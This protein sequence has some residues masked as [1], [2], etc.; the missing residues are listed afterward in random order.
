V[1]NSQL[2]QNISGV[3]VVQSF[4]REDMNLSQFDGVNQ[5]HLDT[6][7]WAIRL[8]AYLMPAVDLVTA[9]ALGLVVVVGGA[10]ALDGELSPAVLVAFAL[11]VQRFFE[12][13]RALTMQ[14]TQFQRAMTA[15]TRI[16]ELLDVEPEVVDSPDAI[17]L[18]A[19]KGEIHYDNISFEYIKGAPVLQDI[20]LHIMPGQTVALV[21][22][23]G[24]GKTT[25]VSLL[26]RFY[27]VTKGRITVDGHDL[28]DVTRHSLASQMS[29][30][31]QEP[32]LY[33]VTVAENIRFR[34]TDA[35]MERVI[36]AA[37]AVGAHDFIMGLEDGYDTVLQERGGNLSIGQ[38]Q[39]ISFARAILADPQILV[40]DEATANID[41]ITEVLIQS[42]LRE[43]LQNRTAVVIAHRLSTIQNSDMIVVM[44]HGR[45]IDTGTHD[46]LLEQSAL[47]ARLYALNF[48]DSDDLESDDSQGQPRP[49]VPDSIT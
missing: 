20:N 5:D 44:E 24:A 21:G 18:P 10:M 25:M 42:A 15:G 13:I 36:A 45:I 26:S 49:S 31:L 43:L 47:Y 12:P 1:V 27:D 7:L 28:R 8:S 16:F 34:Y 35:P 29:M 39:L 22:Q 23:T 37:T 40:L 41:T 17:E 48:D 19:A 9:V 30:V 14:Y 32:F 33:S 2:Q 11:Y 38:R 6:N 46:Q 3:R 4:N